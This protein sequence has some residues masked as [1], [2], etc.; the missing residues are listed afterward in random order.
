MSGGWTGISLR[1]QADAEALILLQ[2]TH[3]CK[4]LFDIFESGA[5]ARVSS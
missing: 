1:G 5:A 4:T 2:H 3:L